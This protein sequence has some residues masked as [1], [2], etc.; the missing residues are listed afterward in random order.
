VL[1]EQIHILETMSPKDFL[2]F[3]Y[4]LNPASGFQSSQFREIEFA[5]GL[6][7]PRLMKHFESDSGA[8]SQ[9][10]KRFEAPSLEDFFYDLLRGR[11][12]SLPVDD[13]SLDDAERSARQEV[14]I[15]GL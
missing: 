7:E 11:G 1:V 5:G 8:Y 15:N 3:R 6:K 12:F 4:N 10:K 13:A 2:G 9:L 14:R